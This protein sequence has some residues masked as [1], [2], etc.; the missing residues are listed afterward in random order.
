MDLTIK[1]ILIGTNYIIVKCVSGSVTIKAVNANMCYFNHV[2]PKLRRKIQALKKRKYTDFVLKKTTASSS[3]YELI[4]DEYSVTFE[5]IRMGDA[6]GE[7]TIEV[8]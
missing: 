2:I 3:Y 5:L 4:A 7:V 6:S 1:D 8:K